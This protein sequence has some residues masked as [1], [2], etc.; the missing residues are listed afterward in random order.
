MEE[1][2]HVV[3]GDQG[4]NV[5]QLCFDLDGTL[6]D[7]RN[8]I[9]GCLRHALAAVRADIPSDAKLAAFIGPPLQQ[10]LR[11][12]LKNPDESVLAE[13]LTRYRERFSSV[14]MYDNEVYPGIPELL[15][16]LGAAGWTLRVVTS[17]P[18]VFADRILTHF[19]LSQHFTGVHG[20]EL[21]GVRSDKAELIA[22]V[23][24]TER[25]SAEDAVMIGDRSH[26]VVGA[27]ANGVR[28]LGVLWGYGTRAELAAA[29]ADE[30]YESISA[31]ESD[32][33][34]SHTPPGET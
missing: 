1:G 8:G 14:G 19:D 32:L 18:T 30:L 6:T 24:E 23:L 27:R 31:L 29:G 5:R 11:Q 22:H 25:I 9:V 17:K 10:S 2:D 13:A 16:A 20:S 7:P 34:R 26:D 21:S 12:L 33:C 4:A 3:A 28:A 15:R